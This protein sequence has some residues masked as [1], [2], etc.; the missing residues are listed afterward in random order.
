M[1]FVYNKYREKYHEKHSKIEGKFMRLQG[2]WEFLKE[3]RFQE[4]HF[5]IHQLDGLFYEGSKNRNQI[6]KPYVI[7]EEQIAMLKNTYSKQFHN[8]S[9]SV[10]EEP[11]PR[12]TS[13]GR[14][15]EYKPGIHANSKSIDAIST[16]PMTDRFSE[17]K[18]GNFS[19]VVYN[20]LGD[21]YYRSLY[22]NVDSI[23]I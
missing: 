20:T 2:M 13:A 11:C 1:T 21:D 22:H 19:E 4:D 12:A 17:V 15:N 10:C 23:I 14:S 6:K 8:D 16:D 5:T 18:D 9:P 7:V 3:I